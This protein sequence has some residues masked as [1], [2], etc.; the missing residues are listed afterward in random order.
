[1]KAEFKSERGLGLGFLVFG[2]WMFVEMAFLRGNM[3]VFDNLLAFG[4]GCV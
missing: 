3:A 1:M 2:V 4:A